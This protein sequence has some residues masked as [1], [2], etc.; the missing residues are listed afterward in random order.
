MKRIA[1][2]LCVI[3]LVIGLGFIA[4]GIYYMQHQ[5]DVETIVSRV[6]VSPQMSPE[7]PEA[8]VQEEMQVFVPPDGENIALQAKLT[9]SGHTDVYFGTKAID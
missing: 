3:L 2:V 1:I 7:T 5:H 4:A 8:F 6:T 9:E